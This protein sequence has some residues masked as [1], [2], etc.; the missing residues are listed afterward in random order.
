MVVT[1]NFGH[2]KSNATIKK[3]VAAMLANTRLILMSETRAANFG[4]HKA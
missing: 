2:H 4:Y 3:I 1:A